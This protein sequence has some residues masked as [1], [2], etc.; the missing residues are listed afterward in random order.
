[1]KIRAQNG[2]V[3]DLDESKGLAYDDWGRLIFDAVLLDLTR[4]QRAE[5]PDQPPTI[6]ETEEPVRL[7]LSIGGFELLAQAVKATR[8]KGHKSTDGP[9]TVRILEPPKWRKRSA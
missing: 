1:M 2:T 9:V 7:R 4:E 5:V 6:W 8:S 3:L